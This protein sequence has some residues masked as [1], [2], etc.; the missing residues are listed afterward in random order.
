MIEGLYYLLALM[1]T[2]PFAITFLIYKLSYKFVGEKRYSFHLAI[3]MTTVLYI[4]SVAAI[5]YSVFS[6]NP[7]GYIFLLLL[8]ILM[9]CVF[10]HWRVYTDI[11]FFHVCKRFWKA[12]FLLFFS[13]HIITIVYGICYNIS[14]VL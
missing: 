13:L 5:I 2:L 1:I 12:T 14:R 11:I 7:I 9:I 3:D 4:A 6:I 8:F 10:I